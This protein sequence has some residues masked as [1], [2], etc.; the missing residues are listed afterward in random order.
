MGNN[1]RAIANMSQLRVPREIVGRFLRPAMVLTLL[2]ACFSGP[3]YTAAQHSGNGGIVTGGNG[4]SGNGSSFPSLDQDPL[5]QRR[6]MPGEAGDPVQYERRMKALNTERQKSMIADTNK[7]LR[8]TTELNE[9]VNGDH[10]RP[11][12][13]DQLRKVAQ[14]EKLA[15]SVRDKMCTPVG[16]SSPQLTP[17][18]SFPAPMIVQ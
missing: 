6:P 11:L 14:I 18:M 8:L 1:I 3:R 5:S 7:L 2:L 15:R 13:S 12:D 4:T 16:G 10:P 9:E 17:P